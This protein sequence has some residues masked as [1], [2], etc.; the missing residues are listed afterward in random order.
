MM[1]ACDQQ[2]QDLQRQIEECTT[3]LNKATLAMDGAFKPCSSLVFF[4]SL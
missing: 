4:R 1:R 2:Q 3:Q